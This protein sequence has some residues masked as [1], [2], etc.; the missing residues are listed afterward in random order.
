MGRGKNKTGIEIED[1]PF[2]PQ[3]VA[4]KEYK[5]CEK[6]FKFYNTFLSESCPICSREYGLAAEQFKQ[7]IK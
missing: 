3:A 6:C 7:E 2:I 1:N 5:R 4:R